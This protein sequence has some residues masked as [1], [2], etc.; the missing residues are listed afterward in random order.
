MSKLN[1]KLAQKIDGFSGRDIE[2][3]VTEILWHEYQR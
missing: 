1:E 3:M 2:K